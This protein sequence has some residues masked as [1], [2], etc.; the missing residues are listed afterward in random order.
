MSE[1][2]AL[3]PGGQDA[4]P[5]RPKPLW[6]SSILPGVPEAPPERKPKPPGY[7][8]AEEAYTFVSAL[9]YEVVV[10]LLAGETPSHVAWGERVVTVQH[11][12]AAR[13]LLS[14]KGNPV[15]I[16]AR[17]DGPVK[18]VVEKTGDDSETRAILAL[19]ANLQPLPAQRRTGN[20]GE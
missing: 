9:P 2:R 15:E 14:T 5:A 12:R 10:Q 20:E 3:P 7:I 11:V 13:E 1:S 19:L 16:N 8:T 4:A 17:M 18:Q 6:P